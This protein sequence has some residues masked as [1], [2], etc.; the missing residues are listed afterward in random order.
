MIQELQKVIKRPK[1]DR[2]EDPECMICNSEKGGNC[3]KSGIVYTIQCNKC[4]DSYFGETHRNGNSRS[5]EHYDAYHSKN[6]KLR[7]ESIMWRHEDEKHGGEK[8]TFSMRVIKVFQ[9]DALGR[10]LLE[11]ILIRK[12]PA[13][14]LINNKREFIQPCDVQLEVE[15][16]RWSMK[17]KR[18]KILQ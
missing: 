14:Q 9:N 6:K 1:R 2:C 13:E 16:K 17:T 8:V 10:Q 18:R 3:R 7:E 5:K 12:Q 4:K 11:A 15:R